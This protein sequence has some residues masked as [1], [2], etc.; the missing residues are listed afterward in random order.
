MKTSTKEKDIYCDYTLVWK[1]KKRQLFVLIGHQKQQA[2]FIR[3]LYIFMAVFF[4][5]EMDQFI[6]G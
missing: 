1:Y 5:L 3:R 4:I 6:C 2:I